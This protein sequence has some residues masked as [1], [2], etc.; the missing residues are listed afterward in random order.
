MV[1][2]NNQTLHVGFNGLIDKTNTELG[3]PWRPSQD[4]DWHGGHTLSI[5]FVV[6]WLQ[7]HR[8]PL[9]CHKDKTEDSTQWRRDP[10][11]TG[12]I[13]AKGTRCD[14]GAC[15]GVKQGPMDACPFDELNDVLTKTP[16]HGLEL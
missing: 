4:G 13:E 11:A 6:V 7:N 16:M 9:L 14:Q 15:I 3:E 12:S 5:G 8:V 1:T 10:S 2:V